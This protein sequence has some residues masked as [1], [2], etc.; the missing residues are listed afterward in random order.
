MSA[1]YPGG[2]KQFVTF[3]D[4]PGP[5]PLTIDFASDTNEIHDEIEAL[6]QTVGVR[7][8]TGTKYSQFFQA[9]SDLY[10]YKASTTH[11]HPH[12]D[13]ED[14]SKNHVKNWSAFNP[15]T[16]DDHPQYMPT[17]AHRAFTAPIGG[18]PATIPQH[19]IRRDQI[20]GTGYITTTT[21][22]SLMTAAFATKVVG[23]PAP[24]PGIPIGAVPFGAD[25]APEPATFGNWNITGG[26]LSTNT[27]HAGHAYAGFGDAFS[28]Y[29]QALVLMKQPF[30][31][32]GSGYNYHQDQVIVIA[33]SINGFVVEFTDMS[34]AGIRNKHLTI[35]W[36][37]LGI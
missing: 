16:P 15:T 28:H 9:F 8:L 11:M 30:G 20:A 21:F 35:T 3:K 13:M 34:G 37:A 25:F 24:S 32:A 5:D 22:N 18:Q 27:D 10:N 1:T 6:E 7:P 31:G 26:V 29:I 19:L 4:Q 36:M 23:K 33:C 17:D 12:S 2:I 14:G